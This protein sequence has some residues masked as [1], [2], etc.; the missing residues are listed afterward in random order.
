MSCREIQLRREARRRLLASPLCMG[1]GTLRTKV[2]TKPLRHIMSTDKID[3][4]KK[5][6]TSVSGELTDE[7]LNSVTGGD[8]KTTTKTT[9]KQPDKYLEITLNDT[10]IS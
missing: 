10:M 2:S 1:G 5:D 9:S 4:S 8:G 6:A 7:Q 3:P